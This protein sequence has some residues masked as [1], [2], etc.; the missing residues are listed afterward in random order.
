MAGKQVRAAR[1]V[2]V[3]DATLRAVGE[4]GLTLRQKALIARLLWAMTQDRF[5]HGM[6][7]AF[8]QG[9][10]DGRRAAVEQALREAGR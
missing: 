1:L 7:A 6:S 5:I 3:I 8:R 9:T 4:P 10:P 2:L